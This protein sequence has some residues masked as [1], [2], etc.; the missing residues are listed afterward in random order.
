MLLFF[1]RSSNSNQLLQTSLIP[2]PGFWLEAKAKFSEYPN[3][4]RLIN[5]ETVPQEVPEV[6]VNSYED[7]LEEGTAVSD[8]FETMIEQSTETRKQQSL[9]NMER[10]RRGEPLESIRRP[11]VQFT[12]PDAHADEQAI[13][14]QLRNKQAAGDLANSRMRR[15]SVYPGAGSLAGQQAAASDPVTPVTSTPDPAI[16]NLAQNND[17]NIDTIARQAKEQGNDEVVISLR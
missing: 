7:I 17:F 2:Y 11:E 12:P 1:F 13:L 5:L 6:S 16:L 4:C 10:A 9:E 14:E 15:M 8:K 3:L